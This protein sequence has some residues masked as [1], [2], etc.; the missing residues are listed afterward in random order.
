MLLQIALL[1]SMLFQLGAAITAVSLIRRT[2]YN[3]SWILISAG[4]VLM[5]IRRL[6]EFYSLFRDTP[7]L[8]KEDIN[9]WIGVL[10]S[11]L[12]LIGLI[13]IRQIFNLLDEIKELRKKDEA[14]LLK[15][16]IQTEEKARQTFA[17]DL[18]D[19]LGPVLSSI[20]MTIS[21]IDLKKIDKTNQRI[22][23]RTTQVTDEAITTLK[24]I[25]NDLSPHLL[26]NYGLKIALENFAGRLLENSNIRFEMTGNIDSKRYFYDLE[27]SLF[28][29]IS[30]L[31]NN[32]VSHGKPDLITINLTDYG[33]DLRI[34]YRDNGCGY[35]INDH[36]SKNKIEGMGLTNIRSRVKSLNGYYYAYSELNKGVRVYIQT[37]LK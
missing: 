9:S 34:E 33:D 35:D 2:R 22:I 27:I 3:V 11:L 25:S 28:R 17:R 14:R 21:A 4:F 6:F 18:H 7:L 37:P 1:L 30:E 8:P 23:E 29:I 15:V 31:M 16:I 26:K 5:A 32:S 12:M 10:I 24:E 20:K 13:Y 19:G 36:T